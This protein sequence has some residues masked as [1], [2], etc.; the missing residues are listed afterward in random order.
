MSCGAFLS[1]VLAADEKVFS[2][3]F[4]HVGKQNVFQLA[5]LSAGKKKRISTFDHAEQI[6]RDEKRS[7]QNEEKQMFSFSIDLAVKNGRK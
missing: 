7:M 1:V 5:F 3:D 2:Q 4:Q 6:V